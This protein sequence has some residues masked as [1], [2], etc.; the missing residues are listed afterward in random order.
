VTPLYLATRR[1]V[2]ESLYLALAVELGVTVV[3]AD[4]RWANAFNSGPFARFLRPLT[5]R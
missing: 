1:T 4:R 2:Y 5:P 3:T